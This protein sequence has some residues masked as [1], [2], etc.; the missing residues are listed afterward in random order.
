LRWLSTGARIPALLQQTLEWMRKMNAFQEEGL[1][2]IAGSENALNI[3]MG[4][5]APHNNNIEVI[6]RK[7]CAGVHEAATFIKV[8]LTRHKERQRESVCVSDEV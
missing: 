3:M 7:S 4:M 5:L 8:S 1:F 6:M 2:R